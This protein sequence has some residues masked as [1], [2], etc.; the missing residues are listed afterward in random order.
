VAEAIRTAPDD[1]QKGHLVLLSDWTISPSFRSTRGGPEDAARR[2][3]KDG[4]TVETL[5]S[6]IYRLVDPPA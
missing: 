1:L 5:P 4:Y 3:K 2:L 6:G